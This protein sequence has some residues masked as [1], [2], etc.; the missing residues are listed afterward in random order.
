MHQCMVHLPLHNPLHPSF[1]I[2][3]PFH[4]STNLLQPVAPSRNLS[5]FPPRPFWV[6]FPSNQSGLIWFWSGRAEEEVCLGEKAVMEAVAFVGMD[7]IGSLLWFF[8]QLHLKRCFSLDLP[9]WQESCR[10]VSTGHCLS[11]CP[12]IFLLTGLS[13]CVY[14]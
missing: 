14:L 9:S 2:L 1:I 13:S 11:T 7:R 8:E 4:I 12:T 10:R 6:I 5:N 3:L